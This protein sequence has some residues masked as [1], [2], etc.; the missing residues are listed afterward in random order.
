MQFRHGYCTYKQ[1]GGYE[2]S[3]GARAELLHD[4]V[5]SLLLHVTMLKKSKLKKSQTAKW[6]T[7]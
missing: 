6:N 2:N 1:V 3:T 4:Y 5:S 7:H